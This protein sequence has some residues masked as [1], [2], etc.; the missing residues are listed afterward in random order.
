[1]LYIFWTNSM[2]WNCFI[3]PIC[4]WNNQENALFWFHCNMQVMHGKDKNKSQS[5][6]WPNVVRRCLSVVWYTSTS[7]GRCYAIKNNSPP[8]IFSLCIFVL[9]LLVCTYSRASIRTCVVMTCARVAAGWFS[10]LK[11]Y[12]IFLVLKGIRYISSVHFMAK[13]WP[14]FFR[15]LDMT[16]SWMTRV[17]A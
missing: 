7:R 12:F 11:F 13:E 1:M 8:C 4:H 2:P 5:F 3:G 14:M 6:F 15:S 17:D 10:F 9:F 16:M